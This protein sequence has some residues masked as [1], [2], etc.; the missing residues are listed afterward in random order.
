MA[1]ALFAQQEDILRRILSDNENTRKQAVEEARRLNPGAQAGLI[2]ALVAIPPD[3][4]SEWQYALAALPGF[5]DA[6]VAP[7]ITAIHNPDQKV[8]YS[9]SVMLGRIGKPALQPLIAM[10]H[11]PSPQVRCAAAG[12]LTVMRDAAQPA[13]GTLVLLLRDDSQDVV[14][15]AIRALG[16]A[17]SPE[18]L[19]ALRAELAVAPYQGAT[20]V[21]LETMGKRAA[22]ASSEVLPLLKSTNGLTRMVAARTLGTIAQPAP[23]VIAALIASL[24]DPEW[25]P[26]QQ[27]AASLAK[28]GPASAP[29]VPDLRR[30]LDPDREKNHFVRRNAAEA[31]GAIG[32]QAKDAVPDMIP[33][34][35]D[36]DAYTR[37][38]GVEAVG[39]IGVQAT[40]A[41]IAALGNTKPEIRAGAAWQLGEF[42]APGAVPALIAS[43]KDSDATVHT[44]AKQALQKIA[45]PEAKA[46]L[47][48]APAEAALPSGLWTLAEVERSIPPS[49][50]HRSAL[51]LMYK[52]EL[53]ASPNL[54]FLATVHRSD[55]RGDLLRIW[56]PTGARYRRILEI[57]DKDSEPGAAYWQEPEGFQLGGEFFVHLMHLSPGTG[58]LHEDRIFWAAPDVTLHEA[59]FTRP[60]ELYK[61]LAK[62]EGIWKGESNRFKEAIPA[63]SFGIW[64][65]GDGNCCPSGGEVTGHYRLEGS[66]RYDP[67][68][69]RWSADFRIVPDGFERH[70]ASDRH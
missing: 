1:S 56:T 51:K 11:E 65:E 15:C 47:A 63:F 18:A 60:A 38:T 25:N 61:G 16:A 68:G 8:R 48:K 32:P 69:K 29:A 17:G 53:Q 12:S 66:K 59:G 4:A 19:A 10:L 35:L 13:V 31:L 46:A 34:W 7:L 27:A 6:A 9:A 23:E 57:D 26:R 20:L 24:S 43:L 36:E 3:R 55:D 28:F 52:T 21:A 54:S 45:T 42:P 62:S 33:L 39:K 49:E 70:P 22:E 44:A 50:G 5:G 67:A 30:L 58:Y 2:A 14:G 64:R 40:P 41:L 37:R